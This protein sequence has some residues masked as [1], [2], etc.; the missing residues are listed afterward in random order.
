MFKQPVGTGEFRKAIYSPE[1]GAAPRMEM[2]ESGG[3]GA[4][5]P[6]GEENWGWGT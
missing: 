6:S 2:G 5:L 1:I 3:A 4:P